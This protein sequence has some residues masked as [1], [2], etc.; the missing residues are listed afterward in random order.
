[1]FSRFM[2]R[3]LRGRLL[4]WLLG[5]LLLLAVFAIIDGYRTA[6]ITADTVSD[7]VLSGSALAIAER[8]FVNEDDVLEV[9]VPYVALQM[10]TTSEDDRVFYRIEDSENG[11]ITGYRGLDLPSSSDGAPIS[12]SNSR[13]RGAPVRIAVYEGAASSN[14][15]SLGF[16]VA[17]AE[18]T[19]A[20][21]AIATTILLRSL[22]RQVFF[23][24]SAAVLIWVAV[25]LALRPLQKVEAAVQR[26]SPEDVRPIEH[27]VPTE[28]EGLVSTING[29]V[30]RFAASIAALQ[31]FTSNASHQFRTPLAV[32]KTH[33]DIAAREK[34][35]DVQ[36]DAIQN[37][38]SAVDDAE[39]LM[40]QMLLL[41]RLD[42]SSREKLQSDTCDLTQ[43]AREV[44]EEF[45]LQLSAAGKGDV[46]LGFEAAGPCMVRSEETLTREVIRNLVD[47]A[48]KHG[49]GQGASRVD[50]KVESGKAYGLIHVTDDGDGFDFAAT[51]KNRPEAKYPA[52]ST[53]DNNSGLGLAIVQDILGL[54]GGQLKAERLIKPNGMRITASFGR[55]EEVGT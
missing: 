14:E 8:V 44:C 53:S 9:D 16:R 37:A 34:D 45:V 52:F 10:L 15:R 24:L 17:I 19:N 31:N 3:S 32:I 21:S 18:T 20:R 54:V 33:L 13:F 1:M 42:A 27:R 7:R 11:F 22:A 35:P 6:R 25:S 30:A 12:F 5:P 39:R 48:V 36:R 46:D 23:L 47:N 4:F 50:V 40:R 28:I 38:H 43:V 2:P 51:S 41:A 49:G 26:R 55:V 29:L